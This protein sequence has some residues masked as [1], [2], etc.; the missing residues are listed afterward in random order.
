MIKSIHIFT[1][2]LLETSTPC[3]VYHLYQVVL[4]DRDHLEDIPVPC[5]CN[6]VLKIFQKDVD[7]HHYFLINLMF[8]FD[9]Y[10]FFQFWLKYF[11][12]Q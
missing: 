5:K 1:A 12:L 6:L 7:P 10:L 8:Y 11:L 2:N 3:V 9:L 4:A